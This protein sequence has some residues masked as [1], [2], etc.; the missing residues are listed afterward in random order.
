MALPLTTRARAKVNL[1]LRVLGRRADGYHE[2]ESLV[3]FAGVGDTLS[4]DPGAPLS[5]TL[6]GPRAEGL[7]ADD[8]NL[9]LRAARALAAA[10]PGLH[11][12]RFHLVK[13]LPVASGIGGGSADAAAA[14]RL[15]AR[16]NGIA[17]SDP[18]LRE[19]AASVGADVPVC[20][21][22]RARLMAGIGE[23]LGPVLKLPPLFAV[24]VNP[25]VGVETVAVFRA[26]GLK[27]G[28]VVSEARAARFATPAS[29]AELLGYLETTSNDLAAPAQ[30]VAPVIDA[31]LERLVGAPGCRLARMSGSGATCFALFDDCVASAAAA[32]ALQREQPG[33]WVKPTLLR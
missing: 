22:S 5:L 31:V 9:V 17:A 24:L 18:V 16:L 8:G 26:L 4:L 21:D 1:D 32:K 13:R 19:V 7:S 3:A 14:L 15:L 27:A 10:R 28:E 30:R 6:A 12:G 23:K 29:A 2:L 11:V 25:G 20:L 33:W